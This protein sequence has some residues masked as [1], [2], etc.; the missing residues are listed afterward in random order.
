MTGAANLI[1]AI[2]SAA[3]A[4]RMIDAPWWAA[5]YVAFLTGFVVLAALICVNPVRK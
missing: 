1:A 2:L 4:A 3:V 5:A